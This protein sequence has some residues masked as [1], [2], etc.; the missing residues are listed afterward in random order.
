MPPSARSEDDDEMDAPDG[1]PDC[2]EEAEEAA[3]GEQPKKKPRGNKVEQKQRAI[4]EMEVK[5]DQEQ[6]KVLAA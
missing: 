4:K 2:D 1:A 5:L 6:Q 3:D